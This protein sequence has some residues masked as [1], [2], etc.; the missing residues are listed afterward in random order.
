[1]AEEEE[2]MKYRNVDIMVPV[3][4]QDKRRLPVI[5]VLPKIDRQLNLF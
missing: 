3:L 1:M 2:R 4:R 5:P